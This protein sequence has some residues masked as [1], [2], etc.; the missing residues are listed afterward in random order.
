MISFEKQLESTKQ[1][2]AT[3]R[4]DGILR[5]HSP[6]DIAEQQG[7]IAVEQIKRLNAARLQL[8]VMRV[9]GIV[10][11][12]TDAEAATLLEN[13]TDERDQPFIIGATNIE[14]PSYKAAYI[15]ML[16]I[17]ADRGAQDVRGRTAAAKAM[18][19]GSTQV[20]HLV[21]TEVPP[22][23]LEEWLEIWRQHYQYPARIRVELRPHTAGSELLELKV[24]DEGR[25]QLAHVI[26]TTIQ[27]RRGRT[28]LV[29]RDQN[30]DPLLRMKRL[31]TLVQ[32]FLIDRYRVN[33][34]HYVSPTQ[35]NQLQTAR[36]KDLGIFTDVNTE[37]GQIIV[38]A[39]NRERV[40]DLVALDRNALDRLIQKSAPIGTS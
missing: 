33:S 29:I 36:M 6:R 1:W 13:R 35:D 37:V 20:Q 8:D 5:L 14:V 24:L 31:M 9:P 28:I 2:V 17:L 27:D 39:V 26:C 11:A 40:G 10:V 16:R 3:P 25:R 22:G 7:T 38:A 30:T 12:R 34:V 32:L 18:S 23:L 19:K 21:Q 15:A 4:F